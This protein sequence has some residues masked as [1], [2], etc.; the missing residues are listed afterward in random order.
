[1]SKK[2]IFI[3]T[4]RCGTTRI[5]QI[6]KQ[7]LSNDFVVVHQMRF[8]RIANIIGNAMH[9]FGES[10]C[11]K[12]KLY[13]FIISTYS[14]KNKYFISTDPLTAMIVPKSIYDSHDTFIVHIIRE[15][16]QFSKSFFALSRRNPKSFLA[17]N[18]IPLWQIGI[19]P[20]Q[21]LFT[22]N[23]QEKY[24]RLAIRKNQFF[25]EK[26]HINPNYT[27]VPMDRVF[28]TSFLSDIV[29]SFFSFDLRI[30]PKTL[31]IKTN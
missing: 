5:S 17:H 8:S 19:W 10:E 3:S 13:H 6:L 18:L 12:E 7:H 1:M 30:E 28:K 9:F 29:G 14:E 23:I 21:N 31:K 15:P 4:G 11:I 25:E 24:A 20:F 26:F 2:M 27:K 16:Y 22:S